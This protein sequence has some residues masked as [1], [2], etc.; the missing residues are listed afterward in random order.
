[1]YEDPVLLLCSV[2]GARFWLQG[3]LVSIHAPGKHKYLPAQM[4]C[5]LSAVYLNYFLFFSQSSKLKSFSTG[6]KLLLG[7]ATSIMTPHDTWTWHAK[8]ASWLLFPF[9]AKKV[10]PFTW[11]R[12]L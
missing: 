9:L 11:Y 8:P 4:V 3:E 1:M 6:L 10:E 7:I 12:I 2:L 5:W